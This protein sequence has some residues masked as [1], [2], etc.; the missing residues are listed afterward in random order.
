MSGEAKRD[1][2]DC[3]ICWHGESGRVCADGQRHVLCGLCIEA[4]ELHEHFCDGQ[5]ID[6]IGSD[7]AG[8]KYIESN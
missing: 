5:D 1:E 8:G 3:R 7:L 2:A 4:E 6:Q